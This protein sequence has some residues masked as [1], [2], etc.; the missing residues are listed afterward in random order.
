MDPLLFA[1]ALVVELAAEHGRGHSGANASSSVVASV[2]ATARAVVASATGAVQ[3]GG[4]AAKGGGGG[5]GSHGVSSVSAWNAAIARDFQYAF[6]LAVVVFLLFVTP[7]IAGWAANG[8]WK[9]GWMLRSSAAEKDAPVA[10]NE[11]GEKGTEKVRDAVV[12]DVFDR[13][14]LL[15]VVPTSALTAY[16]RTLYN[17]IL[18]RPFPIFHLTLGQIALCIV[19]GAVVVFCLFFECLDHLSN[20]NRTAAV[21][22]GQLPA[23]FLFASKNSALSALGQGYEKMN[24]L[25]RVAGRLV[26]LCGLLHAV[27]YL[28]KHPFDLS[29]PMQQSGTAC[30]IACG[31]LLIPSVSYVRNTFYQFFLLSHIAGWITFLVGLY[32]HAP[33]FA[34]PYLI[35][36]FVV[37]GL[38]VVL[39]VAKTRFGKASI[40][41]LP[42]NTLMIQSHTISSGF[43]PG[44]HVWLRTWKAGG[45]W[46]GWETHPFTIASAP[47]GASPLQGSHRL[48]LLV[49]AAG[50]YTTALKKAAEVS[51]GD[52]SAKVIG[53]AFEGPYGGPMLTDFA[54][55]QSVLLVAGGSGITFC[56]PI[57]EELVYLAT[58]G[59]T[60]VRSV[61]LVWT[62]REAELIESYQAFLGGLVEV[63]RERTALEVKISL[64]V[65]RAPLNVPPDTRVNATLP[66]P[67]PH[68]TLS[69][70]RPSISYV[71]DDIASDVVS[72]TTRMNLACG[73]G[74][75]V[76]S[77]GPRHLIEEVRR[78]VG[79]VPVAKAVAVGGIVVCG[80]TF[81][82]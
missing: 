20:F 3:A 46:R 56:A 80:E 53:C 44:Q 27:F 50:D 68:S 60:S 77:C 8:R 5:A 12:M 35:F 79:Q 21:G 51:L 23:L 75:V 29:E 43:R 65:T 9:S 4:P 78:A 31:L 73:G 71:L 24:Y 32:Y 42:A 19:Y 34:T 40:V 36:C 52:S 22:V 7:L 26:V 33:D 38:D 16:L 30:V 2:A 67:V 57:L 59:K 37:Y 76:G 54:D 17:R 49:K 14:A 45:W 11:K 70:A 15:Q 41:A 48:T 69:L 47:E 39:R 61:T 10:V 6:G 1:R 13:P 82:W 62:M 64:H 18:L 58:V 74:I 25:H 63:A 55:A 28:V 81:G 72:M 66:S